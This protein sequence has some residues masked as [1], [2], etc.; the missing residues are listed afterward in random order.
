MT[1]KLYNDNMEGLKI[2]HSQKYW[3]NEYLMRSYDHICDLYNTERS[4]FFKKTV[5]F[6]LSGPPVSH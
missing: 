2:V 5:I 4:D 1:S 6:F 3:L